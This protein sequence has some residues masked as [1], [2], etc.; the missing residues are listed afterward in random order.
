MKELEKIIKGIGPVDQ[1]SMDE[2][3]KCWDS[4]CKRFGGLDGWRKCW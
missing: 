4:L 3:W 2:A 1:K